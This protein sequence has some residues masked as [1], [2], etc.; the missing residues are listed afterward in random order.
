[1]SLFT[2]T[3]KNLFINKLHE[4]TSINPLIL[5][6]LIELNLIHS[7]LEHKNSIII[8]DNHFSFSNIQLKHDYQQQL[9]FIFASYPLHNKKFSDFLYDDKRDILK[10]IIIDN[11]SELKLIISFNE[12][13]GLSFAIMSD[14]QLFTN[15]DMSLLNSEELIKFKNI[16]KLESMKILEFIPINSSKYFKELFLTFI[17]LAILKSFEDIDQHIEKGTKR[18]LDFIQ[19][20]KI[21]AQNEIEVIFERAL[22]EQKIKEF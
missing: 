3:D 18:Y 16:I 7:L 19:E 15:Y 13:N 8:Q 2:T 12:Y 6:N 20:I 21:N 14:Y 22:L 11:N 1:M 4:I 17:P 5:N 9:E 10:R